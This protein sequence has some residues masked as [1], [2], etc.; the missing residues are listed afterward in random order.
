[1]PVHQLVALALLFI[2]LLPEECVYREEK[3]GRGGGGARMGKKKA[4]V[5]MTRGAEIGGKG[6]R[7]TD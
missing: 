5:K 6:L 7:E 3:R 1:M 2:F 4:E